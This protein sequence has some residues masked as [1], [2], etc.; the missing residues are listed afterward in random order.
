MQIV[1]Q[2]GDIEQ[3]PEENSEAY[4]MQERKNESKSKK[5]GKGASPA[6]SSAVNHLV[7]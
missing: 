5:G 4:K 1:S 7:D 3:E 6:V 2:L